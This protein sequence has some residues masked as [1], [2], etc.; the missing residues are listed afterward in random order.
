MLA[1]SVGFVTDFFANCGLEFAKSHFT[2]K[3]NENQL[4]NRLKEF[5]NSQ[6]KFNE[7][8]SL[9]EEIDFQGFQDYTLDA[10]VPDFEKW[11]YGYS[12]K[13][14]EEARDAIINKCIVYSSAQTP[15]AIKRVS[16][17][18]AIAIS[19]I[20]DFY[21]NKVD[22]DLWIVANQIEDNLSNQMSESTQAITNAI[23]ALDN[24]REASDNKIDN[25][26]KKLD[27]LSNYSLDSIRINAERGNVQDVENKL[28][29]I[30]N[31]VSTTHPLFPDY[32]YVMSNNKL[33]SVPLNESAEKKYP[34]HFLCH[35]TVKLG[36]KIINNFNTST[37]DFADR[38][39]LKISIH[40][41]HVQK[42]LGDII[43]KAPNEAI[44]MEG[45]T[46]VRYPKPFPPAMPYSISAGK[47]VYFPYIELRIEEI[48]DNNTIILT[49]T[50]Q[51]PSHIRIRIE[52]S[53]DMK[54]NNF[55][56]HLSSPTNNEILSYLK[57]IKSLSDGEQL[58]FTS[59]KDNQQFISGNVT[60][61]NYTPNFDCIDDEIEFLE[62][63]CQ[64]ERYFN[65]NLLIPEWIY[66]TDIF[67]VYYLSE[68]I[69]GRN[70]EAQWEEHYFNVIVNASS[71][72]KLL[73]IDNKEL[74]LSFIGNVTITIFE[75]QYHVKII[76]LLKSALPKDV[77]RF[78][79]KVE[80]A[81]DG[82]TVKLVYVAGSTNDFVDKIAPEDM[83]IGNIYSL[84]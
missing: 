26:D 78:R 82:E 76:R 25:I 31:I 14:C 57:W 5:L 36:E 37:L 63:I 1:D 55:Q 42:M 19:I 49:N 41:S 24:K 23:E 65:E 12:P 45:K 77:E 62:R 81:D 70:I 84:E 74:S 66:D 38:H 56:V 33:Y 69:Q 43:D 59:L 54:C 39:Q 17:M 11:I 15:E 53:E 80:Y 3:I 50:E 47:K 35:G 8:C 28:S 44:E 60:S 2:N 10:L 64:I 61:V 18:A 7:V 52:I 79:K 32:R 6:E 29:T 40:L 48:D 68:L 46:L 72:D 30:I 51:S 27:N 58:S 73:R 20:K 34:P 83:E 71:R 9:E 16:S 21:K 13:E 67:G 4:K 22:K 75:K